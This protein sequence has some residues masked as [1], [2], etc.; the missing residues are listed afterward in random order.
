METKTFK[1]ELKKQTRSFYRY[2]LKNDEVII[3]VYLIKSL[4]DT[5]KVPV[6][7]TVTVQE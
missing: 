4:I 3:Q 2:E 1:V 7:L 6:A 5:E